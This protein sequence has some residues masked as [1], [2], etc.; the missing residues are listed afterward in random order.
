GRSTVNITSCT[1]GSENGRE[2]ALYVIEVHQLA[3]DGNYASG[4]IVARRY[5]EFHALHQ[6]LKE[7]YPAVRSYELPGKRGFLRLQ[8]NFVEGR[9]VAL[10]K[11]LQLL[12]QNPDVCG[13]QELRA[14]LSQQNIY[15]PQSEAAEQAAQSGAV[16]SGRLSPGGAKRRGRSPSPSPKA[17]PFIIPST[18]QS[19]P[20]FTS[21]TSPSKAT[22]TLHQPKPRAPPTQ[23]SGPTLA[24]IPVP[25]LAPPPLAQSL[26]TP[27]SSAH[28][29]H[30]PTRPTLEH[31]PSAGF[32]KHIYKT[33]AEGIDDIFTGPSMLDIITQR[34]GQQVMQFS[35]QDEGGLVGH[36][37]VFGDGYYTESASESVAAAVAAAAASL[38]LDVGPSASGSVITTAGASGDLRPIENE[39]MTRFTEPLCD[40]FIEVFE[41]KEKNNWLRR[42]AVV[43]ILQQIMGGTIERK[44]RETTKQLQ[45]EETVVMLVTRITDSLYPNGVRPDSKLVRSVEER[46]VTKEEANRKLSTWLPAHRHHGREAERASRRAA[47]FHRLPE[48]TTEPAAHVY[49]SRRARTRPVSGDR[50]HDRDR[51]VEQ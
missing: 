47:P 30:P 31:L 4:W 10:E 51:V 1:I 36:P 18:S 44:L 17:S 12:I 28:S 42:Q 26:S 14:F 41:L 50:G 39:G 38:N 13:S 34:L 19:T 40:L 48:P 11:Y 2:F 7:R 23:P 27:T 3:A 45:S 32:M 24:P 16:A 20:I 5:S 35:V 21:F 33:V 46:A 49:D 8:R 22:S 25:L 29:L 43:I 6:Q 37:H 9:R 15:L